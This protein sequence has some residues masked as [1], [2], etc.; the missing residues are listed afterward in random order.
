M[1]EEVFTD[2]EVADYL[3]EYFISYKVDAE[4]GNGPDITAIYEVAG[5]PTLLFMDANGRVLVRNMGAAMQT[6]FL[7]LA[8]Q[9]V[10]EA[11]SAP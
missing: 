9:A 11:Q 3:N 4:K 10:A 6:E 5:Y 7:D 8:R 2:R 1:D